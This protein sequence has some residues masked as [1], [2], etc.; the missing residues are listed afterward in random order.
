MVEVFAWALKKMLT[1][2]TMQAQP[3]I[4]QWE[5]IKSVQKYKKKEN[6]K[7]QKAKLKQKKFEVNGESLQV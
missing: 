3:T 7:G 2:Q 6:D 4:W 5:E 1:S